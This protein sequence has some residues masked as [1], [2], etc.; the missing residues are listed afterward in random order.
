M[1]ASGSRSSADLSR[2]DG[3]TIELGGEMLTVRRLSS[4]R[5][6]L[7]EGFFRS[8]GADSKRLFDPHPSDRVSV[9]RYIE[10]DREG[11]DVSF[12]ACTGVDVAVAYFFLWEAEEEVPLLGIGISDSHQN[13]GLGRKL[14]QML[15][16][17]AKAMDR[18]GIDLTTMQDN[19]RAFHLY[20][21]CGFRYLGDVP[22]LTGDGRKVFERRMFLA[23]AG[24]ATPPDRLFGPPDLI[25]A[26]S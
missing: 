19:D 8:L 3:A 21:S 11:S 17:V 18:R 7:L 12:L 23:L 20:E 10:R 2:F 22:N 14:M 4:C 5:A 6:D 9:E 16:D 24:G 25:E 15:I 13:R 1:C 26:G